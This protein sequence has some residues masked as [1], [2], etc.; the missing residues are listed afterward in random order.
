MLWPAYL[1]GPVT[2]VYRLVSCAVIDGV[3]RGYLLC[4]A[5]AKR[6][7]GPIMTRGDIL[8]FGGAY[9]C[10]HKYRQYDD[11]CGQPFH[12]LPPSLQLKVQN[13]LVVL[14]QCTNYS[15]IK[16]GEI[17]SLGMPAIKISAHFF[18]DL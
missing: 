17:F 15:I 4:P 14:C 9:N 12:F 16:R 7:K 13:I 2:V 11:G 8:F 18:F 1:T 5:A 10:R 6:M 3:L